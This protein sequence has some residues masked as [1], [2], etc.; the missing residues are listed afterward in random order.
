MLSQQAL[1][2][3]VKAASP[4]GNM[5]QMSLYKH[6]P[7]GKK[8]ELSKDEM[9]EVEEGQSRWLPE[10]FQSYATKPS[11]MM[12]SPLKQSL[13]YG[14]G[15]AALGGLGGLMLGN[16]YDDSSRG[17][18]PPSDVPGYIGA[19]VGAL[20]VGGASAVM[21]YLSRNA[22]NKGI[23]D[24][25]QRLPRGATKRD[26]LADPVYNDDYSRANANGNV[27]SG[28]GWGVGRELASLA[29]RGALS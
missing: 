13:L 4:Y 19:L 21:S 2:A 27:A 17:G 20:G 7:V 15:G 16:L 5:Q 11:D 26:M 18:Q 12:A 25:M 24:Q 1:R 8:R 22:E 6:A 28:L 9:K 3:L 29:V 23:I 10:I 14:T